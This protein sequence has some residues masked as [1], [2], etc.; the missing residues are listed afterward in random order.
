M[1]KKPEKPLYNMSQ[2]DLVATAVQKSSFLK[3]D[4]AALLERGMSQARLD[5]LGLLT[6]AFVALPTEEEGVQQTATATATKE[7][8]RTAALTAMQSIMG[9]VRLWL[10]LSACVDQAVGT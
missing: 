1:N 3:R 9:K 7:T 6:K 10:A 4:L 8:T 2:A 5:Q